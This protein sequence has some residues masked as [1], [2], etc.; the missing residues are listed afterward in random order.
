MI[1]ERKTT[2]T[3]SPPR[4]RKT[5]FHDISERS[6][7]LKIRGIIVLV[8]PHHPLLVLRRFDPSIK[9]VS[10]P[11]PPHEVDAHRRDEDGTETEAAQ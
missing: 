10:P 7:V 4:K 6:L 3:R 2:T 1:P 5:H 9:S 11:I 8:L